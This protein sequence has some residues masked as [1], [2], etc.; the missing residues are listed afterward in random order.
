M[1]ISS[2][3]YF[4]SKPNN[5][6]FFGD[7][8]Q[9][10]TLGKICV[11]PFENFKGLTEVNGK[12]YYIHTR[13]PTSWPLANKFCKD[14]GMT[15]ASLKTEKEMIDLF[16][17]TQKVSAFDSWWVSAKYDGGVF[18]WE[19]GTVLGLDSNIW[20]KNYSQPSDYLKNKNVC[21]DFHSG[22]Y[23]GLH[24]SPC[25][26]NYRFI[27]ETNLNYLRACSITKTT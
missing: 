5:R 4:V 10:N 26:A 12:K 25:S 9:L 11:D 7:Q 24:D 17:A 8:G 13:E 14:F 27:C 2:V 21:T 15:L 1:S 3:M 6:S 19:D 23:S 22:I 18:K 20:G 16:H